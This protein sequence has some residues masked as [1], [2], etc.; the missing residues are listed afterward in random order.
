M[1]N[2]KQEEIMEAIWGA[3]ENSMHSMRQLKRD[4]LLISQKRI[5]WNLKDKA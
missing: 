4:A 5:F 1:L 3:G 2:E